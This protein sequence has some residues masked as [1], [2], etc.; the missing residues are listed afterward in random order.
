[1]SGLKTPIIAQLYFQ[2][3]VDYRISVT[4]N[5]SLHQIQGDITMDYTN[6]SPDQLSFIY[7]HLWP[8][9]Y[10]DL[11][12]A[13]AKQSL[14]N[15]STRF[16]YSDP[17]NRGYIDALNFTVDGEKVNWEYDAEHPDIAIL[18][19][20]EPLVQGGKISISTPFRV[21]IPSSFSRLGRVGQS[22]QMTQWYPKPA[23]YDKNG[24][25]PMPYLDIGE[26]Y[27]EFGNFEVSITLPENYVVG[28]TGVLQEQ[29]EIDWLTQKAEEDAKK[30]FNE[31]TDISY[32]ISA[33]ANKTI[34][35]K[36]ENVHD[37]AWFADKR[38]YVLKSEVDLG[39]GKIVDTWAM[40]TNTEASLWKKAT[41]YLNRSVAYYSERV[42]D[43]P[44][45]Q[46]TAVQSALSAGAGMEYP[47]ITV[48]GYSGNG[49]SLDEVITHEVGHNW[50]YGILASNE[51][52]HPWMDEGINSFYEI[53]YMKEFYDHQMGIDA[54]LDDRIVRLLDGE[55]MTLSRLG[56]LNQ[57]R[58]GKEQALT[59]SSQDYEQI[60]YWLAAYDKPAVLL[61]ILEQ[62]IGRESFDL[63]MQKYYR[64]WQ[65]TH[66]QP[67]DFRKV[68]EEHI[69][70]PMD[71]FFDQLIGS[72][73]QIDYALKQVD[74]R[75]ITVKNVGDVAAP[76][77]VASMSNGE[78]VTIKW[79]NGFEGTKVLDFDSQGGEEVIIDPEM[80]LPEINRK[81]NYQKRPVDF[82]FLAGIENESKKSL[83]YAPLIGGNAY[84][85]FM[86]G[87]GVYNSGWPHN[88]FEYVLAPMYGFGSGDPVGL[89]SMHFHTYPKKGLQRITLGLGVKSFN[90][91]EN[92]NF[93][94]E[95]KYTRITPSVEIELGKREARKPIT[96]TIKFRNMHFLQEQATF[97][98]DTLPRPSEPTMDSVFAVYQGNE[99]DHSMITDLY[100]NLDIDGTINKLNVTTGLEFQEFKDLAGTSNT[101]LK[102]ITDINYAFMYRRGRSFRVRLYSAA[103]VQNSKR[104]S[105]SFFFPVSLISNGPTDYRYDRYF[106]A[107]SQGTFGDQNVL[108]QQIYTDQGGFKT[109][110]S[111]ASNIGLSNSYVVSANFTVDLP[112]RFKS[113]VRPY[114]DLG[115]F[116]KRDTFSDPLLS[117]FMWN[118]GIAIEVLN[119]TIG[120]YLPLA[121]SENLQVAM[122][123]RGDYFSRIAFKLDLNRLNP[124]DL[125]KSIDY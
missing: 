10:K 100:Y 114:I 62:W 29:S 107:R 75:V 70:Y 65:F 2:Q 92:P 41:D 40:F 18:R 123:Q 16:Y 5:D 34:T 84:D 119:K 81:N 97:T 38:F 47:M 98:L 93:D 124:F 68:V 82:K 86:L 78:V 44:W 88:R 90:F 64:D 49:R 1:M 110:V 26:F 33:K 66:P 94:Y 25:N 3:Q 105:G 36:A 80:I 54:L 13:F 9:A 71:W 89:A 103:F 27:S 8:N 32:P 45:P 91:F 51:R 22:Y 104:N 115:Y 31:S 24:W 19:L 7:M 43:Y 61:H 112:F 37:F 87:L 83:Y 42:G 48:I 72:T 39:G 95:L 55:D 28:A 85:K 4:L 118:F 30:S 120:I 67:E 57:A 21:Q 20:N 15:G 63:M 96:Q 6:N 52:N 50:F 116:K 99:L 59:T 111:P 14:E 121:S 106:M 12:T 125:A 101:Y 102:W 69:G 113:P 56:Y 109:A 76:F 58:R 108:G 35:Y 122:E 11:N 17:K 60:N 77:P 53:A 73:D 79:F 117:S 23:V 74:D 46:A